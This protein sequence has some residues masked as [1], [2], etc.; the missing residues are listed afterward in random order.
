LAFE[1]FLPMVFEPLFCGQAFKCRTIPRI[2]RM[3]VIDIG[4]LRQI[5]QVLSQNRPDRMDRVVPRQPLAL[6]SLDRTNNGLEFHGNLIFNDGM[7]RTVR[8][9]VRHLD[10]GALVM[11]DG[12]IDSSLLA[13]LQPSR[14]AWG[15][16]WIVALH[17]TSLPRRS[18][19]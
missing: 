9:Q 14:L 13:Q 5:E 11:G 10:L 15:C 6:K 7:N 17:G 8:A 1:L 2:N 18:R 4:L 3:L 12:Q 16:C 19:L